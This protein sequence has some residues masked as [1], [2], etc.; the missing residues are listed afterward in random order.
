MDRDY[1]GQVLNW[2]WAGTANGRPSPTGFTA[3]SRTG[4]GPT[5]NPLILTSGRSTT[6]DGP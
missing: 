1:L 3:D 2:L 4:F 6:A 5:R